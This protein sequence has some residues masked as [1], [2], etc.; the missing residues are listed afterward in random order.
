MFRVKG[1]RVQVFKGLIV[2]FTLPKSTSLS[3]HYKICVRFSNKK[4]PKK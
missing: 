2:Y 4:I 1:L 3:G